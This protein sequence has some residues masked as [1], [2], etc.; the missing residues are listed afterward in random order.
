M[1]MV[2]EQKEALLGQDRADLRWLDPRLLD[3]DEAQPRQEH[4]I[5]SDKELAAGVR[6][7]GVLVPL[8]VVAQGGGR[9]LVLAGARRRS[10]AL[11][12]ELASVPCLVL[13][14]KPSARAWLDLQLI[15]N[16]HRRELTP[17]ELAQTI[18][19]RWLLLNI[20][21][22]EQERGEDGT[23]TDAAL[24]GARTP[25]AQIAALEE[26]LASL[27]GVDA[28]RDY[29]GGGQVRV[30]KRI[31]LEQLGLG[32]R[33]E[34]WAR[35]LLQL[36]QLDPAVQAALEGTTLQRARCASW[37][38]ALQRSR[39]RW[40]KRPRGRPRDRVGRAGAWDRAPRARARLDRRC[41]RAW[42][43]ARGR[44]RR[45]GAGAIRAIPRGRS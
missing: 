21:A 13:A 8:I 14:E 32:G 28:A 29:F 27:A 43:G 44:G 35:K 5:T 42:A 34:A 45:I 37:P 3:V 11:A 12:A 10:A 24:A 2:V 4:D 36:L 23:A 18:W 15:E 33:S 31:A 19:R 20:E 40:S 30:P 41:A 25:V 6:E 7:Q 22:F 39:P 9:Y 16:L 17:L 38:S 1:G 26:R